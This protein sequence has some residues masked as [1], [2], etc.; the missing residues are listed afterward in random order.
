[1]ARGHPAAWSA[2]FGLPLL[3]AGLAIGTGGGLPVAGAP[4]T[5]PAAGLAL[6]ALGAFVVGLGL[7]VQFVAAPGAPTMREGESVLDDR[8][9]AQRNALGQAVV[10]TPL[11]GLGLYLLYLTE[12]P[13]LYPTVALAGGLYL[14]S[15]GLHRYW[16]NTLT[17]YLL[18][19][20]RVI[21]EYRF[22]S[23]VRNEVPLGKV[24]A[25]EESR[26]AWDSLFG[27]GSVAVRSGAGGELTVSVDA[28]YDPG[29]FAD[30][31]REAIRHHDAAGATVGADA[32]SGDDADP[33]EDGA[34]GG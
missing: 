27:L 14:L 3:G 19:D 11:L 21:E 24:R 15:R 32:G 7:Y 4:A 25:V 30:A 20:R 33:V 18:T 26:S 2:L 17:T 9:P 8:D 6:A 12:R 10:G 22:V 16:R 23:L 34:D 29:E 1:M 28:V 31:I 13:Y 5:P